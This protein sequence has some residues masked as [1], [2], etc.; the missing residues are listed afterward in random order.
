MKSLRGERLQVADID[1]DGV[2]GDRL[3]HVRQQSGR[4][5]TS[6]FR[7]RLLGLQAALGE[8]GEPTIDGLPWTSA[9]RARARARG[10]RAGRRARR[11]PGEDH[12]QR[13]DVLPLTVVTESMVEEVGVDRRRFRPN[14][15]IAG[16]EG[17]EEIDWP[18]YGLR[19]GSVLIGVRNRRARCVMT[20]FDPDSLEQDPRVL[21]RIVR[22]SAA[23]SRST[24]GW[25]RRDAS[26]RAM[27]SS[28]W[29]CRRRPSRRSG[30]AASRSRGTAARWAE[31]AGAEPY[32][33]SSSRAS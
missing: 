26:A 27:R 6:R 28:S 4:V 19:A 18:G 10:R 23:R 25:S 17:L 21:H 13:Y 32:F 8:D 12:G 14:V 5:V 9:A 20:T 3:V 16:A 33:A 11:G 31:A 2:A 22:R 30:T 29:S 7:P 24:A 15:V 1:E